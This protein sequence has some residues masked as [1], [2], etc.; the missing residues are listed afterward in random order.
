M[1]IEGLL[2]LIQRGVGGV[3]RG[4]R[5]GIMDGITEVWHVSRRSAG[6]EKRERGVAERGAKG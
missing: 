4:I 3:R 2:T 1:I 5:R 6:N